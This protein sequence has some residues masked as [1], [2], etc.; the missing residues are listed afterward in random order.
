M[1]TLHLT[2]EQYSSGGNIC[3]GDEDSEWPNY[4]TECIDWSPKQLLLDKGNNWSVEEIEVDDV[5]AG[6]SLFIIVLR[7]STGNTFGRTEGCWSIVQTVKTQNDASN[8][9]KNI[10][11]LMELYRSQESYHLTQ[12][13]KEEKKSAERDFNTFRDKLAK[14]LNY[15]FPC[16]GY[17]ECFERLE[18]HEMTVEDNTS[19]TN[20][21]VIRQKH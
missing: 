19:N 13:N 1:T 16:F 21:K 12:K 17:F 10:D 15:Y 11:K 4:E 5:K 20:I 3:A 7:Y 2:Y 18:I 8:I 9:E 6:D 14:E